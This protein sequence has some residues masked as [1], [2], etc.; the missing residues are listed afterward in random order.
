MALVAKDQAAQQ[1]AT[2]EYTV[3]EPD[4]QG[5]AADSNVP[6][7]PGVLHMPNAVV[8]TDTIVTTF[9]TP[10]KNIAALQDQVA[11]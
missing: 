11:R 4:D 2:P 9:V 3:Q 6:S 8:V 7:E 1:L 10:F 5:E